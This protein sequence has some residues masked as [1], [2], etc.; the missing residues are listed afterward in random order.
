MHG[1]C[2]ALFISENSPK[3]FSTNVLV[4][5]NMRGQQEINFILEEALLW[6]TNLYFGQKQQFKFKMS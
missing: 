1:S 6:S 2:K 3:Q 4:D 5:F